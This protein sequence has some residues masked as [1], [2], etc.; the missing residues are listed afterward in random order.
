MN[1]SS[2]LVFD[3]SAGSGKTSTLVLEY[4]K[5]LLGSKSDD[6]FKK[7]L[8]LTFTNKAVEEM[9]LRIFRTL[10]DIGKGVL[11]EEDFRIKF[12]KKELKV[13]HEQL[14]TKSNN[15]L[16]AL[17][18]N[19]ASFDI[20]TIDKFNQRLVRT[21]SRDLNLTSNYEVILDEEDLIK[22]AINKLIAEIGNNE[23]LSQ[24]LIDFTLQKI[25]SDKSFNIEYDLYETAKLISNE[26]HFHYLKQLKKVEL[27]DYLIFQKNIK[28]QL[29]QLENKISVLGSEALQ[30]IKKKNIAHGQ[31]Y[32]SD[33]PNHFKKLKALNVESL[34]FEGRLEKSIQDEKYVSS[35]CDDYTESIINEIMPDLIGLYEASKKLDYTKFFKLKAINKNLVPSLLLQQVFHHIN[36]IKKEENILRIS[37]FNEIINSQITAQPAPF[38]YERI[39]E[40]YKHYFLDE[41]QDTSVL[42]WSNLKPLINNALS[43][44]NSSLFLVGDAKQAIYQWRGGEVS[45]FLDIVNSKANDI[46]VLPTVD[47]LDYNRRSCKNIVEFNNAFFSEIVSACF[48]NET[49]FNLYKK[50]NQHVWNE[51]EGAVTVQFVD[52]NKKEETD[53]AYCQATL[54]RIE[55]CL[56]SGFEPYEIT[57]LVRKNSQGTTLAQYLVDNST[58]EVVSS[59]SLLLHKSAKVQFI[60]NFLSLLLQPDNLKIKIE[61]LDYISSEYLKHEFTHDF[62]ANNLHSS[63]DEIGKYLI[64]YGF[65][66]DILKYQNA[67]LLDSIQ[68][69]IDHFNLSDVSDSYI[70]EI[71]EFA[72]EVSQTSDSSLSSFINLY[73]E[74]VEKRS[75]TAGQS[76]NAVQIMTI[77]KAKG[78]EF[79]VVIYPWAD[80]KIVDTSKFPDVWLPLDDFETE[81][82]YALIKGGSHLKKLGKIGE[83]YFEKLDQN[84]RLDAM[85]NLYVAL[86]RPVEELHII[87]N[88][89]NVK[90]EINTY[91]ALF[92]TYAQKNEPVL[93]NNI[94]TLGKLAKNRLPSSFTESFKIPYNT[95]KSFEEL[96]VNIHTKNGQLWDSK[97]ETAIEK[98]NLIHN[99]LAHIKVKNDIDFVLND[100]YNKG[101]LS[102]ESIVEIKSFIN[103]VVNHSELR[104]YYTN[105]CIIYNEREIIRSNGAI[106]IPDKISILENKVT[107]IDYKTGAFN[108]KHETQIIDYGDALIELGYQL[109]ELILVYIS[110]HI[111]IKKIK[112]N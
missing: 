89:E 61:V 109:K 83:A 39:G 53:L 100:F 57:I 58:T 16:S 13:T 86:T 12:L 14:I 73:L 44:S 69:I 59:E 50:V 96:S 111:E 4:I 92:K 105:K 110:D 112:T 65:P 102:N 76:K 46:N 23:N 84:A 11:D 38:I 24:L 64:Q 51:K 32:F 1:H 49:Y 21:F 6:Y 2:F 29:S 80:S 34:N 91:S 81:I 71:L 18:N 10:S 108:K 43:S 103:E 75:I 48:K 87:T 95:S 56:K 35:K 66:G 79:P 22:K 93:E 99:I 27:K 88:N 8:A 42:Q 20:S 94:L 85:N 5:R 77:H 90:G 40:R 7:F 36:L 45:Q 101:E 41:F 70:N 67:P 106:V 33:L 37:E 52:G 107:I 104:M 82:P 98:G 63:L 30:I 25:D 17:L 9:K 31:F 19:Y 54:N 26:T 55:Y 72:Y 97:Q 15:V 3:A 74:K 47:S 78:L 68:Q 60:I 28:K 62:I